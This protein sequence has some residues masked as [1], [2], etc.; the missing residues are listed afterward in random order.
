MLRVIGHQVLDAATRRPPDRRV[1][2]HDPEQDRL[3]NARGD[4]EERRVPG[5]CLV[6]R[7]SLVGAE[8]LDAAVEQAA[9]DVN[10]AGQIVGQGVF[11]G[12]TRGFLLTPLL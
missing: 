6:E 7:F 5:P 12:K 9:E 11:A 8:A 1:G 3:A 4:L 2:A 10:A